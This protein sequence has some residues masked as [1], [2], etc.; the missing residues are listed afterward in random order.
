[1]LS[2]FFVQQTF[3]WVREMALVGEEGVGTE[4]NCPPGKYV[5]KALI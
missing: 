2:L 3:D 5:N 1:M 4:D